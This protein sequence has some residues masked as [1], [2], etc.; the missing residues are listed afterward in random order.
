MH[1]RL[2]FGLLTVSLGAALLAAGCQSR[3][4]SEVRGR[5]IRSSD[6]ERVAF[7]QTTAS[8]VERLF[9]APDERAPDGALT[10][11]S[12]LV[13][14]QGGAEQQVKAESVTFRFEDGVL[15]RV[16]RSRQ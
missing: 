12:S 16:C 9:G 8:E 13:H 2:R 1:D 14:R 6:L 5:R 15:S 3:V 10:Y 7:G 11:H 4:E